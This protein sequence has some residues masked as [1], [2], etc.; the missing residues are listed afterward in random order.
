MTLSNL[1]SH[2]CPK[3]NHS[4]TCSCLDLKDQKICPNCW[5][6]IWDETEQEYKEEADKAARSWGIDPDDTIATN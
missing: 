2:D 6:E 5:T 3:G 1:H 4:W